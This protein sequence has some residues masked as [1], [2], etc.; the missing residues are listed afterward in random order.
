MK[1]N[2]MLGIDIG[3]TKILLLIADK[4]GDIYYSEKHPTERD[5]GRLISIVRRFMQKSGI[6]WEEIEAVGIGVCGITDTDKGIV[7]AAPAIGWSDIKLRD[8]FMAEIPCPVYVENDVNCFA[9]GELACGMLKGCRNALYIAVGTG[10]GGAVVINGEIYRGHA[11]CA[12]EVGL[13]LCKHDVSDG[14]HTDIENKVSGSALNIRASA[15]GL[16]SRELFSEYAEKGIDNGGIIG[17]FK[18]ELSVLIA[19]SIS[20]LN[21]E[22]VIIGGGVAQSMHC[23]IDDIRTLVRELTP[24]SAEIYL[25][26]IANEAGGIGAAMFAA[27]SNA[28]ARNQI[29]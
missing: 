25:S 3:G 1:K 24:V 16:T 9:A 13:T 26:G 20:L 12:G 5:A 22:R 17:D 6:S 19:N 8:L 14:K 29:K 27:Q 4:K 23:I 21:P 10:I 15:Y 28:A 7:I 11:F 2:L 18:I